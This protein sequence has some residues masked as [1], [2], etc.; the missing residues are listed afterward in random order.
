MDLRI[1]DSMIVWPGHTTT[2]PQGFM[3]P[4]HLRVLTIEEVPFVFVRRVE[5]ELHCTKDELP[6]P[7][8]NTTEEGL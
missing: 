4:T 2:K 5:N 1:N 3:I 7:H 8:F 6:C